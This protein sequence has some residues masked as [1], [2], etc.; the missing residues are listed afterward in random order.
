MVSTT[1]RTGYISYVYKGQTYYFQDLI[2]LKKTVYNLHGWGSDE[3]NPYGL[4][5]MRAVTFNLLLS[6]KDDLS[7]LIHPSARVRVAA[8]YYA[9]NMKEERARN[10]F[11]ALFCYM[12]EEFGTNYK[13]RVSNWTLGNEVNSCN[14]WNYS[15]NMS[16][17]DNVANYA[18]A[19]QMLSQGVH[20]AVSSSRVFI[21]L[22]HCWNTADAGFAGKAFLD[23]FAAYMNRTAPSMQWNVNYHPYSQPLN[24]SAFWSDYSNTTD[25]VSTRYISMRN[26]QVLT[27]YL[28]TL[29]SRYGK[30][31]GSIRVILGEMG[32]S[33]VGG[34]SSAEELQ[35]AALGY[36]Y[37]KA[38]FNTRV[39]AY[40]IRA[41][42]DDPAETRSGLYLGLRKNDT[43][44][45]AK[46]AYEVYK[47][48]DTDQ[49]LNYMTPYRNLIGISSW[50]SAIPG[51]DAGKLVAVDF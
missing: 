9:L 35:A 1:P 6:W 14:A 21:S 23:E 10:T 27:D 40:I 25:S 11:E 51:F 37:Y 24:R 41:Y 3:G 49:S 5:H 28:G 30:A 22:D 39:D 34:E 42:L 46:K 4:S 36:G 50:E 20:R 47:Y 7:Y 17:Q 16:L 18:Q 8:P 44:Q 29:E 38:M 12:G 48:L 32:Y 13:E 2:A 26:I 15:G 33:A 43:A 19:F 31:S 45:T